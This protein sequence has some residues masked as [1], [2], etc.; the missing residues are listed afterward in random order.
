M[1][2]LLRITYFAII[3]GVLTWQAPAAEE[4]SSA[5]YFQIVGTKD[6]SANEQLPLKSAAAK[7]VI[8]GTIAHVKLTQ[9]YANAGKS[10]IEAVYVF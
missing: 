3:Y 2:S 9:K 10:P 5:P 7:V 6:D 1:K 8:D 4:K